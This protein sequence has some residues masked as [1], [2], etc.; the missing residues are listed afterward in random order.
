[1]AAG[2]ADR[3]GDAQRSRWAFA[4]SLIQQQGVLI[5]LLVVLAFGL[6]RYGENFRAS[7]NIW[8]MLRNNA[9]YGLIA[10]GMTF[11]IMSGG[12]DLSVGAV[13]ALTSVAAARLSSHGV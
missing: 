1:M 4:G 2:M 13:V 9:Y 11:D 6:V 5:A 12:I 8:E 3:G 10:L 7:F